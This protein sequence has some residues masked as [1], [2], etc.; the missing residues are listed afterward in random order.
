VTAGRGVVIGLL[1]T[2]VDPDLPDLLDADLEV[3]DFS[4]SRKTKTELDDHGTCSASVLVGQGRHRISGIAPRAQLCLGKVTGANGVASPRAVAEGIDWLVSC[5]AHIIVIPL[6][7]PNEHIEISQQI[8]NASQHGAVCFAAAGNGHPEPV[9]FPARHPLAI[10]VGAADDSG[11]LLMECSRRP[12]LDLVAPGLE[13]PAAVRNRVV[14]QRGTSIACVIAAGAAALATSCSRPSHSLN[15][16]AILSTLR[17]F[18]PS[19]FA[20]GCTG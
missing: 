2:G 5:G 15:R 14:H 13:I 18:R 19:Q 17:G 3:R 10:A 8:E 6:G 7:E 4:G 1:D 9:S 20:A 12:W 11:E 16:A